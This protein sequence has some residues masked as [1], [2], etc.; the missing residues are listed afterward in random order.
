MRRTTPFAALAAAAAMTV[1]S[2]FVPAQAA[3]LGQTGNVARTKTVA[4]P[5]AVAWKA[6]KGLTGVDCAK[7]TVPVD[8]S[9][10]QGPTIR[11]AI[12]RR[13]ATDAAARIG[14]LVLDPGGPG[15]SGVDEVKDGVTDLY[16]DAEVRRRFD[17][18]G[19]DPRGVGSS[20]AMTCPVPSAT[21][22]VYT[23]PAVYRA[24]Y[25]MALNDKQLRRIRRANAKDE[26]GCRASSGPVADHLD[27]LSVARDID[28]VRSS[29]GEDKLTFYGLSYGTLMGQ[30][31][32]Q[33]F[34]DRVRA[35]VLD[36]NM[37]HSQASTL[38]FLR[39]ES[40]G[41]QDTFD[42]FVHWCA[43]TTKCAVH[44]QGARQAF[45]KLYSRAT[46]SP[47]TDPET[48]E[49]VSAEILLDDTQGAQIQPNWIGLSQ[50]YARLL[51]GG[52]KE[53]P[54]V[55]S[56]TA[57]STSSG[58]PKVA[59][60]PEKIFCSDWN[61]PIHNAAELRSYR[62]KVRRVAPDMKF[63]TQAFGIVLSCLGWPAKVTNP[64][65]PLHW[66]GVPPVLMINALYDPA[67]P[68]EWAQNASRQSGAVLLTYEGW[69]HGVVGRHDP[70][71]CVG[72]A[73]TRYLVDLV[74][75]AAHTRCR[76][77]KPFQ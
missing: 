28:A 13:P 14:S 57:A 64:Q 12:A 17:I 40:K 23:S 37:D 54:K 51:H 43:G 74:V 4:T 63:S 15:G 2:G 41:V 71:N 25:H 48:G 7:V 10:P 56:S 44:K 75:P 32:A 73:A 45:N 27:N 9:D 3:S 26:R 16:L 22:A 39:S 42:Q 50:Q 24:V 46:R 35:L 36:S 29:L 5:A 69:G 52:S 49:K 53:A 33:L 6:C 58:R 18:V 55:S 61:L 60:A 76:A 70:G 21:D 62:E 47:L 30:Q 68:Y 72:A 19:L 65:A 31:Y 34:P 59:A 11:I 1:A 67:T 66:D 38:D 20:T 77:E 8:W